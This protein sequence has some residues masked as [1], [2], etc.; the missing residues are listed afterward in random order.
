MLI[1]WSNIDIV[2]DTYTTKSRPTKVS[3]HKITTS[4]YFEAVKCHHQIVD[5]SQTKIHNIHSPAAARYNFLP[6]VELTLL[7]SIKNLYI[8]R[9]R[10]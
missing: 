8:H 9:N 4:L 5:K 1:S 2:L 3:Q 10:I 7:L 6:Q